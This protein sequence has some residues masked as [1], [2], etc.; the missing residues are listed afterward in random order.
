VFTL[1]TAHGVGV[2][3]DSE[4]AVVLGMYVTA[5]VSLYGLAVYRILATAA[6]KRRIKVD[7]L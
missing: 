6:T 5:L 7:A 1:V 4:N 3:T 2:G